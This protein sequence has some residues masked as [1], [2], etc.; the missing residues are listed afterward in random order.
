MAATRLWFT[1]RGIIESERGNALEEE[2][3]GDS[4]RGRRRKNDEEQGKKI[5]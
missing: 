3:G 2:R 1:H 5:K 4:E